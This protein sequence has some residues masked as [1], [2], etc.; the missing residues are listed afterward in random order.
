MSG[1]A[2]ATCG[3]C[4]ACGTELRVDDWCVACR[5][6]RRYVEHGYGAVGDVGSDCLEAAEWHARN[7]GRARAS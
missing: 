3:R 5:A 4:H 1:G 7:L 2:A 6:F